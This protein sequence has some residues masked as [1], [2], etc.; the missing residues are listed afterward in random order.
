MKGVLGNTRFWEI[1]DARKYAMRVRYGYVI[2]DG[3]WVMVSGIG[4][5][6]Y[7]YDVVG[8]SIRRKQSID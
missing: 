1:R 8:L 2:K 7:L 6:M 5:V 3:V 4:C